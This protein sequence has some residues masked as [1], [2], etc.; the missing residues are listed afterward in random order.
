[1]SDHTSKP[2]RSPSYPNMS[3][4]DAVG[5]VAKIEGLY[6]A[7]PVDR[8]AAARLLGYSSLSG[9]ANKALAALASY[10][11]LERAG[12]GETRVTSRA[13]GIIHAENDEERRENLLAAASEPK[14]FMELRDRFAGI[15]VPPEDGVV[16][17]LN[18]QEFNPSAVK[19]AAKAFLQTMTYIEELKADQSHSDQSS[20][21]VLPDAAKYGDAKVGDFVQWESQ[22]TLQFP[23]P[24][25][26]R[27]VS[28]DGLWVA[29]EGS[30]T[31]IPMS[32]VTVE[33]IAAPET[34]TPPI[35]EFD[36]PEQK[37]S[38]G[39]EEWFRAKVGAEKQ[40][41]ISYR[42]TGDISAKEIQKL[43][44]MLA[45]QKAALED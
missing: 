24:L 29:V 41:L 19:P 15:A 20:G 7:A 10:G 31:G 32:E 13:Q 40:V 6:R 26:V 2:I 36:E 33:T 44:D 17:Y 11:L 12:K 30:R 14:L 37:P 1:M 22:G 45:A 39:F 16:T 34:A 25:R 21:M 18:R 4:R 35:F 27:D 23:K 38:G 5:A 43:I 3:L 28:D 42:G 8:E 9:P